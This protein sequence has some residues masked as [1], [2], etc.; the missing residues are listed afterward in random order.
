MIAETRKRLV[1]KGITP[2]SMDFQIG[3]SLRTK[4]FVFR[5]AGGH[6]A[7]ADAAGDRRTPGVPRRRR[8]PRTSGP[9][10]SSTGSGSWWPDRPP[11][12]CSSSSSS[13]RACATTW[14]RPR[15]TASAS[16]TA[17]RSTTTMSRRAGTRVSPRS[18]GRRRT[19]PLHFSPRRTAL[20]GEFASEHSIDTRRE[21]LKALRKAY[22]D[23]QEEQARVSSSLQDK[24]ARLDGLKAA[25]D[26]TP[27]YLTLQKA[28]S[29]DALWQA[30][31][32]TNGTPDWK[33]LQGRV[34]ATQEPNPLYLELSARM[35]T[36]E[37]DVNALAPRGA[38]LDQRL[39]AL[40]RDMKAL[41]VGLAVDESQLEKAE[42]RA[43]RRAD[44]SAGVQGGRIGG[45]FQAAGPGTQPHSSSTPAP[46]WRGSI[47][48]SPSSRSSSTN[49][50]RASTKRRSPRANSTS[51][52]CA[53]A[54][55][56]CRTLSPSGGVAC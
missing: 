7:R 21:Q 37:A 9:T 24:K 42:E 2:S 52:T 43:G 30:V 53:S 55:P 1:K 4:I 14:R 25:L 45:R 13:I 46:A 26:K 22:G 10:S 20:L 36:I 18:R 29:D 35:A 31:G 41:E 50:P 48:P 51:K 16:P 17:C 15:T 47:A 28:I 33:A 11:R 5:H 3:R 32:K 49:S 8:R 12:R 44:P 54:R 40:S 34:L 6:R 23:L 38:Q 39:A 19:S 27:P 56:P